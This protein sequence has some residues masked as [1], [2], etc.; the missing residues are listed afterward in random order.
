V[1]CHRASQGKQADGRQEGQASA[2]LQGKKGQEF[3]DVFNNNPSSV[4]VLDSWFVILRSGSWFRPG[5]RHRSAQDA[6][7][8]DLQ[9]CILA[10]STWGGEE[11]L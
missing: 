5:T 1:G 2:I 10:A 11:R 7:P 4:E 9:L 3:V 8:S 6:S